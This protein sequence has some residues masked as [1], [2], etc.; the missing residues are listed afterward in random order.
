M[1]PCSPLIAHAVADA[2]RPCPTHGPDDL[3]R[4]PG[5]DEPR[6]WRVDFY[7]PP[8]SGPSPTEGTRLRL[9]TMART[10]Y[11][12]P[13]PLEVIVRRFCVLDGPLK[14]TCWMS[15]RSN[16]SRSEVVPIDGPFPVWSWVAPDDE[17]SVDGW[18]LSPDA[19]RWHA[20]AADWSL[21]GD[22]SPAPSQLQPEPGEPVCARCERRAL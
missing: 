5:R 7:S 12:R 18:A 20:F 4:P 6:L 16:L 3:W 21:C 19:A 2:D 11:V 17:A 13:G 22:V 8:P 14:G 1:H 15:W 10:R 9:D